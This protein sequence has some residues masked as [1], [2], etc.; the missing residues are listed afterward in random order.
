MTED[1]YRVTN[2]SG[3][4]LVFT[5]G[6]NTT[7]RLDNNEVMD[8]TEN[9]VTQYLWDIY[10]KGLVSITYSDGSLLPEPPAYTETASFHIEPSTGELIMETPDD[11]IG[12]SFRLR[13]NNLEVIT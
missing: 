13:R 10:S 7:I 12:A 9:Q 3:G 5:C 1:A 2:I 6:D 11:Y 8:F 4:Q